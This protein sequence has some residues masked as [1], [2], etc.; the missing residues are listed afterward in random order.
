MAGQECIAV[1]GLISDGRLSGGLCS[2]SKFKN[3]ARATVSD[4]Q[5]VVIEIYLAQMAIIYLH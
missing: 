1:N 4:W 2:R 5:I 3:F